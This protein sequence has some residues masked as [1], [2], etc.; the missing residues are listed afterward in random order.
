MANP[1]NVSMTTFTTYDKASRN[2]CR[3]TIT[4]TGAITQGYAVTYAGATAGAGAVILGIAGATV[5]SG[6]EV[7]VVT[8]ASLTPVVAGA[9]F[10]A[11][12]VALAANAS[13]KL[14]TAVAGDYVFARSRETASG[15]GAIVLVKITH[16]G[17]LPA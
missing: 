8:D 6:E 11:T 10:A 7:S 1:T 3:E 9:G 13:G 5:A 2:E 16:E 14:I 17:E 12:G 15:D 4:A